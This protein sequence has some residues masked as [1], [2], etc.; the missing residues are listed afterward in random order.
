[1][2][3]IPNLRKTIEKAL[4]FAAAITMVSC[5]TEKKTA[6]INDQT[7]KVETTLPWNKQEG[8]EQGNDELAR[9]NERR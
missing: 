7:E 9:M 8:W 6:L 4:L 3:A 5:A 1:M 2:R